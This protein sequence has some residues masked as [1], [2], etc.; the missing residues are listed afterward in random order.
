M[1]ADQLSA[2]LRFSGA[3]ARSSSRSMVPMKTIKES[4]GAAEQPGAS[5]HPNSPSDGVDI[6]DEGARGGHRGPVPAPRRR[7]SDP[8]D[9]SEDAEQPRPPQLP[10]PRV[11]VPENQDPGGNGAGNPLLRPSSQAS[12]RSRRQ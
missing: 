3:A 6:L 11:W 7:H 8:L 12:Q 1:D 4:G 10:P 5:S 9:G 2:R